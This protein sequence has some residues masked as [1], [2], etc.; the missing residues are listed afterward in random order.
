MELWQMTEAMS[1][2]LQRAEF[3]LMERAEL[4]AAGETYGALSTIAA[5]MAEA[6]TDW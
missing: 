2:A 3:R 4:G 1:D 5:S 6:G